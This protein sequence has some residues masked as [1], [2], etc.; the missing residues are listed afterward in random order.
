MIQFLRDLVAAPLRLA[1]VLFAV[2]PIVDRLRMYKLI[3]SITKDS[4]TATLL[5][6]QTYRKHGIEA[7][8]QL[9][10]S[11]L[12]RRNDAVIAATIG[13]LVLATTADAARSRAW[14]DKA[15]AMNCPNLP[16]LL[17]L[18]LS[19][20]DLDRP[21]QAETIIDEILARDDMP[22]AYTR[23]ALGTRAELCLR[24]QDWDGA[25]AI[26]RRISNI[27]DVSSLRWMKWVVRL[28]RQQNEGEPF[29]LPESLERSRNA[30]ELLLYAVACWYL[31][32]NET[33]LELV[34]RA[35]NKG[36]QP[37]LIRAVNPDFAR[38]V[39]SVG[40]QGQT[41]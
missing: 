21:E 27:E 37:T 19:I 13:T 30:V 23:S 24:R 9:A 5:I 12:A 14:I 35:R 33:A 4:G 28:G 15:R 8:E 40:S 32:Q 6:N 7:A 20:S 29:R 18:D 34:Q 36:L 26:L 39:D 11:L 1:A 10:D 3:W 38:Y 31:H 25:E 41:P 17:A 2:V 16:M 22:M